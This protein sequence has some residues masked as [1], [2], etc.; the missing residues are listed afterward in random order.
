MF[1]GN[2]VRSVR[3]ADNFTAICEPIVLAMWGILNI[4]QPYRPPSPVMGM[5]LLLL[6]TLL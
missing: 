5:A 6:F 2:K 3:G 4:S 1:L